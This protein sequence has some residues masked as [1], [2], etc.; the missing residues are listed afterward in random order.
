MFFGSASGHKRSE[1][2]KAGVREGER[3]S[4]TDVIDERIATSE[5]MMLAI[6]DESEEGD[7]VRI[8][9]IALQLLEVLVGLLK[10]RVDDDS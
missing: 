9:S 2:G 7:K 4:E 1:T 6:K 5:G 3:E 10:H 8:D